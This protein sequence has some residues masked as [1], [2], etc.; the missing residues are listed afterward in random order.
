MKSAFL[1]FLL[2]I[3][4]AALALPQSPPVKKK[5]PAKSAAKKKTVA[6]RSA[7]SSTKSTSTKSSRKGRAGKRA[8]SSAPRGQMTPTPE[9]YQ[10]IQQAL[11]DK[12]YLKSEPN[13]VWDTASVDALSLFQAD[14]NLPVTGKITSASLIGLGLGP[15]TAG[16]VPSK[17]AAPP[18]QKPDAVPA[19]APVTVP[20][21]EN[22]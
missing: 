14:R 5:T 16:T 12:G 22:P 21:P 20:P 19:P 18:V 2:S 13:G 10:E 15:K 17:P 7:K 1:L 9:R 3:F 6:T 8:V 11:A 4:A